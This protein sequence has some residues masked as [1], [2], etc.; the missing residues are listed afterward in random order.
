MVDN[1]DFVV[2]WV[3]G[4]DPEWQKEKNRYLGLDET[5]ANTGVQRYRDWDLMKYWFRGVECFAP[6]VHKIF[7][8]TCGQRPA[9]LNID[10]EKLVCVNHSDYM[11][12][13]VLPTFNS[14]AIEI[15]IHKIKGLSNHFVQFNDDFFPIN[16]LQPDDFFVDGFPCDYAA[17]DA[18]TPNGEFEYLRMN[19]ML[20][21]NK[22]FSK[23][24]VLSNYRDKWINLKDIKTLFRTVEMLRPWTSFSAIR[25]FHCPLAFTIEDFERVWNAI[26]DVMNNTQGHRFRS[27]EDNTAWLVRY[28]RLMEGRFY[29]KSQQQFG[30]AE[31][32]DD[33]LDVVCSAIEGQHKKVLCLNDEYKGSNFDAT[34]NRIISSFEKIL[35]KKSMFEV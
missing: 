9:W 18:L 6:W 28:W 10:A 32:K 7:F 24:E 12:A 1:I 14:S 11:P 27:K 25:D 3:D 15:G 16:T 22:H 20:I 19:N 30:Y 23:K 2:T 8:V 17:L 13:D 26:P 33:S 35:P 21:I 31:I 29:V 5:D 34:K 4:N